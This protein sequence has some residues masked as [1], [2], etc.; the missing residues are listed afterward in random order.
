MILIIHGHVYLS[1]LITILQ[2]F[3][4]TV[5][6]FLDD[7]GTSSHMSGSRTPNIAQPDNANARSVGTLVPNTGMGKDDYFINCYSKNIYLSLSVPKLTLMRIV[8]STGLLSPLCT[9]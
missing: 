1:F 5:H 7:L 8:Y 4:P 9:Y 3:K 6:Y 2:F